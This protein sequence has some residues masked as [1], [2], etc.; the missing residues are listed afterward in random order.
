MLSNHRAQSYSKFVANCCNEW[1]YWEKRFEAVITAKK[2]AQ[3]TRVDLK[4]EPP[5]WTN[6]TTHKVLTIIVYTFHHTHPVVH[7]HISHA[8]IEFVFRI[9][10]MYL[11]PKGK[12]Q[13]RMHDVSEIRLP[14]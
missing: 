10:H 14:C 3:S 5:A 2:V 9:V 1:L 11:C 6:T 12:A 7:C 4:L 13:S 8:S